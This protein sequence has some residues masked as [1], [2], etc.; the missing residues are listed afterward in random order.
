MWGGSCR[1]WCSLWGMHYGGVMCGVRRYGVLPQGCHGAAVGVP[2][3][4]CEGLW[5]R[6]RICGWGLGWDRD[7]WGVWDAW[8]KG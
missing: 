7:C 4:L 8:G 1:V 2:S 3:V 5:G 6:R